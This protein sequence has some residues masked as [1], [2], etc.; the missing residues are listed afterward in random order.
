MFRPALHRLSVTGALLLSFVASAQA[1]TL[2]PGQYLG[3]FTCDSTPRAEL[4]SI[5]EHDQKIVV[6]VRTFP[7]DAGPY[8]QWT[9]ALHH[10]EATDDGA[11]RTVR[12]LF[13]RAAINDDK[14]P[15]ELGL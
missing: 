1:S 14:A 8:F 7:V 10:M 9:D 6:R 2:E 12:S 13:V 5:T 11:F 15:A 3:T 4:V